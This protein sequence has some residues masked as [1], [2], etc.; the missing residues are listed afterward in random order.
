[1]LEQFKWNNMNIGRKYATIFTVVAITFLVTIFVTYWFLEETS[2][3]MEETMVTNEIAIHSSELISLYHEKYLQIPEYIVDSNDDRLSDYLDDS[4][5]FIITAKNLRQHLTDQEQIRIFAE[6][7]E[8]NDQLDEYFFS[9]IVPNVQQINTTEFLALQENASQLKENTIGLANQLK[10]QA[11]DSNTG[12]ILR[13]QE[14]IHTITSI[15]ITTGILSIVIAF[16]LIGFI[17]RKIKN[18]LNKVV[19]TSNEI[20]AGNLN[21]TKLKTSG[22]DEIGKLSS[23]INHMGEKLREMIIEVSSLASEVDQQSTKV[24]EASFDVKHGSEQVA[25]TIEE[26][27]SGS[28]NQANEVSIISENTS[29][30]NERLVTANRSGEALVT[31]SDEVL[32]VSINGDNQ[33][34]AS[35]DQM[36]KINEMVRASVLKVQSL[37]TKTHSITELVHVIKS[38]AEQTNLL[39]LN[40][41]IEAAR[42]GEAGK[43]FAV[44]AN[45]VRKLAEGVTNSVENITS[46]VFSITAEASQVSK[47]L[48]DGFHEVNKGREQIEVSGQSFFEIKQKISDMAE[49]IKEISDTLAYFEDTSREISTSVEQI[50]AISEESA[51][52]SEEISASVNEQVKTIDHISTSA[53]TLATMSERMNEIIKQFRL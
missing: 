16:L 25:V 23:S 38:I 42:A 52:G 28:T 48:N 27:A 5:Q 4:K 14:S 9:V 11:V 33:M 43:G 41:S 46:I 12:S 37:E 35:V 44:V 6:I 47:E 19:E 3:T 8:N 40:A 1:M 7:I 29:R 26:L 24:A 20:A 2:N 36:N 13:V 10:D 17:G 34:K 32:K 15:L 39:A 30:F 53:K 18:D 51:A 49:G 50:A 31:F 21:F 45:E 22:N